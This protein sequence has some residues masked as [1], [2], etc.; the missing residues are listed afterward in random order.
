MRYVLYARK[1]SDSEERQM[2]CIDAQLAELRDY[3]KK[4]RLTVIAEQDPGAPNQSILYRHVPL[5]GRTVRRSAPADSLPRPV[6]PSAGCTCSSVPRRLPQGRAL[7]VSTTHDVCILWLRDHRRLPEGPYLPPLWQA[8]R[9]GCSSTKRH[10][11]GRYRRVDRTLP[12]LCAE[13]RTSGSALL[14]M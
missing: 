9:P 14:P 2:L 13:R 8:P 11:Q 12:A 3:A 7:S 10:C 6:Q 1:S 5:Q 4:E